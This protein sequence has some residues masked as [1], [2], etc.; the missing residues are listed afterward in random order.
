MENRRYIDSSF[1]LG[2]FFVTLIA[3]SVTLTLIFLNEFTR[4]ALLKGFLFCLV[5][6]FLHKLY[7]NLKPK[8]TA[9]KQ[10]KKDYEKLKKE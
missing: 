1:I 2:V 10:S 3:F 9:Y 7:K 6:Y 4:F 8:I 5:T